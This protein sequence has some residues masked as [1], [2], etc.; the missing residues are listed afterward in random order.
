MTLLS[1]VNALNKCVVRQFENILHDAESQL[2]LHDLNKNA[3]FQKKVQNSK[4][5]LD[6][7]LYK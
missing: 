5:G 6:L 4:A 2:Q 1:S 7:N 3:V